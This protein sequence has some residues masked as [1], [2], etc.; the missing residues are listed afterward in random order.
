M[1]RRLYSTNVKQL[2]ANH[3]KK[4]ENVEDKFTEANNFA[5]PL[6]ANIQENNSENKQLVNLLLQEYVQHNFSIANYGVLKSEQLGIDMEDK[7][8]AEILKNNPG[9]VK[10]D[11]EYF[12][13]WH[14]KRQLG[15]LVFNS[16]VANQVGEMGLDDVKY[17]S[18]LI[19]KHGFN[20][21][22]DNK[23]K[24]VAK[25]IEE[26]LVYFA[27]EIGLTQ[28]EMEKV[29]SDLG[30]QIVAKE[31]D[32][33]DVLSLV[34]EKK[35][36]I[37]GDLLVDLLETFTTNEGF[38]KRA[39]AGTPVVLED[40]KDTVVEKF[41]SKA[42]GDLGKLILL[43]GINYQD[44]ALASK[45]YHEDINDDSA[46]SML[47]LLVYKIVHGEKGHWLSIFQAINPSSNLLTDQ[48]VD[49]ITRLKIVC[50]SMDDAIEI[51][52]GLQER[53]MSVV[54]CLVKKALLLGQR[55]FAYVIYDKSIG[56]GLIERSSAV[57]NNFKK[58]GEGE[59]EFKKWV[60]EYVR[61][62]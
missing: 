25:L 8:L 5:R 35:L 47:K 3:V 15:D 10:S 30:A 19:Q 17:F 46:I 28:T 31:A 9:R 38:R 42:V 45:A 57:K 40:F 12:N 7:T 50:F 23:Q 27:G 52:N 34:Y 41:D 60:G 48:Q 29:V 33:E 58:F 2:I 1:F 54:D 4:L 14:E 26:K 18:N 61:G 16:L 55:E 21:D 53:P 56:N 44:F 36:S 32:N 13:E 51:F 59:E 62:I 22:Q 20:L 11:F 39:K 24:F 6:L 43:F 37:D 49:R